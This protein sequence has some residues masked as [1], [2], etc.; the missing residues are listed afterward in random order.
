MRPTTLLAAVAALAIVLP[1]AAQD[2]KLKVKEGDP[3]PDITLPVAQIEKALPTAKD[4]KDLNLKDL[5]G[6][7]NV[8]LFFYPK[9]MTKG[10]TIE[11]C[12]FRDIAAEFAKADTVILGI[13]TD[14]LEDQEK[15]I[16]K[17]KLN[18]PLLADNEQK[19]A[20]ALGVMADKGSFT[21]RVT[22][23]IDKEG[24]IAKIYDKV[25]P[26]THPDDV[27]KYVKDNLK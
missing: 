9:A 7:K 5:R 2:N 21:K 3:A 6:K 22:F 24:K 12:G 4:D 13:S 25:D 19:M 26:K 14:K 11:S 20:K 16:E 27:L 17:E 18:F 1:A 15:F 23:V 8:V 10:C